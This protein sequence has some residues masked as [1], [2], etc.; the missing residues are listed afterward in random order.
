[1]TVRKDA[2]V[3]AARIIDAVSSKALAMQAGP[4]YVV[5][6]VGHLVLTPNAS[7]AVPGRV[8]MMLEVRSDSNDVLQTF[9][10]PWLETLRPQIDA[11]RVRLSWA[12]V[13]RSDP[14]SCSESVMAQIEEASRILVHQ[15]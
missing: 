1:M 11:L 3:A 6:T 9:C 5:A 8:E 2:L 7:N 4:H 15:Y 13:S 10:E 12:E 14:T